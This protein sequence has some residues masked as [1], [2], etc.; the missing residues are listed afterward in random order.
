MRLSRAIVFRAFSAKRQT[1]CLRSQRSA[2]AAAPALLFSGAEAGDRVRKR[3]YFMGTR[4]SFWPSA[5]ER[6]SAAFTP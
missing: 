2:L 5:S 4:E 1:G 6:I 3:V